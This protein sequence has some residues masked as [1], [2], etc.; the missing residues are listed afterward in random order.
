MCVTL[1]D[2]CLSTNDSSNS[3][4]NT[5]NNNTNNTNTNN[6]NNTNNGNTDNSGNNGTNGNNYNLNGGTSFCLSGSYDSTI[7]MWNCDTGQC[8]SKTVEINETDRNGESGHTGPVWSLSSPERCGS[9]CLSGSQ[10]NTACLWDLQDGFRK[11]RR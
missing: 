5:N 1:R 3:R 8:V 11:I 9:L 7:R 2:A 10:D 6:T 4:N